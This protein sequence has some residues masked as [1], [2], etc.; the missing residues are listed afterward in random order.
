MKLM[1]LVPQVYSPIMETEPTVWTH[2]ELLLPL[3]Q[4]D[5]KNCVFIRQDHQAMIKY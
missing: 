2:S 4:I 3:I 1:V 5:P